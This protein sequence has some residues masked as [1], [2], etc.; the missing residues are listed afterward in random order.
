MEERVRTFNLSLE[1]ELQINT[2]ALYLNLGKG[3]MDKDGRANLSL[4][5]GGTHPNEKGYELIAKELGKV[6]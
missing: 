1:K 6:F 4:F 2:D 3:L 5:R